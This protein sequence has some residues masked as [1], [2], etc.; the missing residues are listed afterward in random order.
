MRLPGHSIEDFSYFPL[1][2]NKQFWVHIF[3]KCIHS[4]SA[5]LTALKVHIHVL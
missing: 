2:I 4:Y 5:Y 1:Q 3:S